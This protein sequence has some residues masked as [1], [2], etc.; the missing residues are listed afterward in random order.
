MTYSMIMEYV[1]IEN[2]GTLDEAFNFKSINAKLGKLGM[3]M[4]KG[5]G[6]LQQIASSGKFIKNLFLAAIKKDKEGV[7]KVMA[8]IKKEDLIK[9]LL[10]VDQLTLHML[11]GPIHFIE[12]VTGIHITANI[13]HVIAKSKDIIDDIIKNIGNI[14]SDL[15]HLFT[16]KTVVSRHLT[17]LDNLQKS[18]QIMK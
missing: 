17:S 9:F 8:T 3:N 5:T 15:D 18:V 11:T 10:N 7:K 1:E 14:K 4:H 16:D 13:K 2:S 12:A 6:L